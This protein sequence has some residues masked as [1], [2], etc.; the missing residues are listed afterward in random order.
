MAICLLS[1]FIAAFFGMNGG[2]FGEDCNLRYSESCDAIFRS[3]STC[4][5][6]M[7]WIFLFFGWELVDARRS[8]FDGIFSDTKAWAA[9]LWRN[10]FLFWSV[11]VGFFVIFPT[12]YI[13][14]IDKVVFL[15]LGIGK[16]WGVVFAMTAF[17]FMG[18]EAYKWAKRVWL[19]RHGMMNRKDMGTG[20]EDLERKTF[21][22]FMD[23][24]RGATQEK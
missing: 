11:V 14:V 7:M 5:T 10:T 6:S 21:E 12:L 22:R 19:R 13:P 4:Y 9:R 8:F 17:F 20:E 16:E 1:S 15:H 23:E 18:A 24:G 3:R 2:H